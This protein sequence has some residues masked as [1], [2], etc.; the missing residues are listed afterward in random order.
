MRIL[1]LIVL[2]LGPAKDAETIIGTWV[3]KEDSLYTKTFT[4][5][6]ACSEKYG[7]IEYD[8]FEYY[9]ETSCGVDSD[10]EANFLKLVDCEFDITY[11]F[12]INNV[13]SYYLSLT[14]MD[15]GKTTL[16]RKL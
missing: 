13:S 4:K 2:F 3:S 11:C 6:G 14:N 8:P 16:Y 5:N 7:N 1:L 15:T 12:E 10:I 9:I